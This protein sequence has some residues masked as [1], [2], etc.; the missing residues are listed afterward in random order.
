MAKSNKKKPETV[1][2][3]QVVDTPLVAE[4]VQD[5]NLKGEQIVIGIGGGL[6]KGKEYPV[7]AELAMVLIKKGAAELKK[8]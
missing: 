2:A 8:V 3:E 5:L 4:P 7:G 6:Q 1:Q